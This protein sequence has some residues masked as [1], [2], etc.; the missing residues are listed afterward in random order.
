MSFIPYEDVPLYLAIQGQEGQYVFAESASISVNHSLTTARQ[1]D[2]QIFSIASYSET[3]DNIEYDSK[4]FTANST[5]TV[6]LGPIGGPPKPLATSIY[7]IPKD[8]RIYFPNGKS[9]YF[10]DSIT[11]DGFNYAVRLYSKDSGWSLT[12]EDAQN[13]FFEPIFKHVT[14]SPIVGSLDVSFYVNK[15][16]LP[17]IFNILGES[18]SF[19]SPTIDEGKIHGYLGDFRFSC[20]SLNN[21]SFSLSPNSISQARASFSLYGSLIKDNSFSADYFNSDLYKQQSIPHGSTSQILGFSSLGL[22]HPVSFSYSI[23]VE[24]EPQ[25]GIPPT[26]L[27]K[28]NSSE[29]SLTVPIKIRKKATTISMSLQGDNLD[30]NILEDGFGGKKAKIDVELHDLSYSSYSPGELKN[31][32]DSEQN[33]NG[34]LH[35]LSCHGSIVSQDLSV[36]S[37]GHLM[38]KIDIVQNVR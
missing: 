18:H 25:Y 33:T 35:T 30:P 4:S 5:F 32:V 2:D 36:S 8:T 29:D 1:L 20:A 14:Q 34:L 38:G 10:R 22:D 27:Y 7:Q 11:P 16:N 6:L 31:L 19:M 9:L 15:G 24:N 23:T 13:G 28:T 37:G 17:G 26:S 12:K 21:F 3:G